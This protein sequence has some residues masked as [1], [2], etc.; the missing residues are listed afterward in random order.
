MVDESG[1]STMSLPDMDWCRITCFPYQ[2]G[3]ASCGGLMVTETGNELPS[4]FGSNIFP[5]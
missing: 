5:K 4:G 3:L 2:G 1:I